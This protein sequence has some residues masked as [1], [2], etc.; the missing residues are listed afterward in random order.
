[1][2]T[3][4]KVIRHIDGMLGVTHQVLEI[5]KEEILDI[6]RE[7]TLP[8]FSKY[9][10]HY[11]EVIVTPDKDKHGAEE[12]YFLDTDYDILSVSKVILSYGNTGNGAYNS[13]LL[14]RSPL[15]RQA[16]SNASSMMMQPV[17]HQFHP[18]SLIEI[19]PK[20]SLVSKFTVQIK[21]VH[22]DH[23]STIPI[24]LKDQFYELAICDVR[25]FLYPIRFRFNNIETLYG[26]IE[27][28]MNKLEGAEDDRKD[29]LETFRQ[30]SHKSAN[31]RKIF[32][33]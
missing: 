32:I 7:E 33:R 8:T 28:F 24:S 21:A 13:G 6:I 25:K 5:S 10:P 1:L 11:A 22:P 27:L 9:F 3:P 29:I 18:P 20:K 31:R 17:T 23:F 26:S 19:F 14:S 15:D 16:A 2:L 12:M 4:T 30:H